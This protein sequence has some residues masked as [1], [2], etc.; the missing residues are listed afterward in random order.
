MKGQCYSDNLK[1]NYFLKLSVVFDWKTN[2][3][4]L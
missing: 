1:S 2:E 4:T 3:C